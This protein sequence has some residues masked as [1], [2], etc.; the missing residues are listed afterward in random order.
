MP[1]LVKSKRAGRRQCERGSA[2]LLVI[3]MTAA[4]S[5]VAASLLKLG[6]TERRLNK[7][8]FLHREA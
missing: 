4:L 5:L 2:L 6:A 8:S 7:S 1:V 3:I